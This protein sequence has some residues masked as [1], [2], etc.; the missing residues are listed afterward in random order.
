VNGSVEYFW[1][2]PTGTKILIGV[3]GRGSDKGTGEGS[4]S[5]PA[6]ETPISAWTPTVEDNISDLSGLP[7]RTNWIYDAAS[8]NSFQVSRRGM[9]IWESNWYGYDHIVAVASESPEE[10]TWYTAT[11][12]VIDVKSGEDCILY[13]SSRQIGL[14]I[15]TVSGSR[16]AAIEALCSDR[17]LIAGN[18]L[19]FDKSGTAAEVDI[20]GV[21][22]SQI[23][24]RGEH[25]LLVV[26][27][28]GLET[29]A[30]EVM[31]T[32][33]GSSV[34]ELW[35]TSETCGLK[36]PSVTSVSSASFAVMLE[37]WTR[38]PALAIVTRGVGCRVLASLDHEGGEWLRSRLGPIE[39]VHWTAS[40][41]LEIQGLLCLPAAMFDKPYPWC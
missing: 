16:L 20:G 7:W 8:H 1:W 9:N 41:G 3:A 28:R 36:Y 31:I 39:E 30:G 38:Y 25:R 14:P 4:G 10:N 40:D 15:S 35:A 34:L 6:N 32:D 27:L 12:S 13:R 2:S 37:S 17:A 11:L 21:D 33:E 18:V 24:W 26:G 23:I 5:T 19:F 29:V 22:A